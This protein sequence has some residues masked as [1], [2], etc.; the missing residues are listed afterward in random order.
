[1]NSENYNSEYIYTEYA[2]GSL[3]N[4]NIVDLFDSSLTADNK[5]LYHSVFLFNNELKKHVMETKSTSGFEGSLSAKSVFIDFDVKE[6]KT[7]LDAVKNEVMKFCFHLLDSYSV[8]KD[9]FRIYFSGCKGF[10]IEIPFELITDK[11]V[12]T[13]KLHKRVETFVR[14]ITEG[15]EYVDDGIYQFNRL[16]RYVNSIN[17]K[18]NLYKIPISFNQLVSLSIDEIKDMAKQPNFYINI[19]DE[20]KLNEKMNNIYKEIL[21]EESINEISK[22]TDERKIDYEF[23]YIEDDI[24]NSASNLLKGKI[25]NHHEWIKVGLSLA[26]VGELGRKPFLMLSDNPNYPN[27]TEM[28]LNKKFD[29]LLN[30]YNSSKTNGVTIKTFYY[31]ASKEGFDEKQFYRYTD[32][33]NARRLVSHFQS[34]LKFDHTRNKWMI[35]NDK[36]WKLDETEMHFDYANKLL[37]IMHKDSYRINDKEERIKTQ[38]QINRIGNKSKLSSMFDLASKQSKIRLKSVDFDTHDNLFNCLN[39]TI[40]LTDKVRFY[41]HNREDLLSLCS[42]VK[43]NEEDSCPNFINFIDEIFRRDKETIKYIQRALGYTMTGFT[44]EDVLFFCY[45]GG[46]NG[47]TT[48]LEI[49]RELFGGFFGKMNVNTIMM[50]KN[51]STGNDIACLTGKRFVSTSEI[52]NGSRLNESLIKDLTGGDHIKARFLFNE[53]FEFKPK[54]KLWMYGNH[55]PVLSG[56]DDGIRRRFHVI[57][58]EYS[59]PENRR[60]KR[61]ELL[62][63]FQSEFSGILNWMLDGYLNWKREGLNPPQKIRLTTQNYFEEM[64]ILQKFIND[65]CNLSGTVQSSVIFR[66]FKNYLEEQNEK[67]ISNSEFKR[68]MNMKGYIFEHGRDYNSWNG[69]SLKQNR[70]NG[71]TQVRNENHSDLDEIIDSI[72]N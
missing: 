57:P 8:S 68:L 72:L 44:S 24:L 30:A 38:I 11:L 60:R 13:L 67:S 23:D 61:H 65:C 17:P 9:Q 31:F 33:E 6:D 53:Y 27:D 35:W 1:M 47:K 29:Q 34:E 59:I 4:R 12:P 62:N 50:N 18:S 39:G 55:K 5:E 36:Y 32:L 64:D 48:F 41:Q 25:N 37:Q 51:E 63:I 71:W 49:M 42:N 26:S 54:L 20:L 43:Y 56:I 3:H 19:T 66:R 21:D 40:E 22:S 70:N 46:A 69:I 14:R 15:F 52:E 16:K 7:D 2:I 45:G 58:F 28:F 10:H